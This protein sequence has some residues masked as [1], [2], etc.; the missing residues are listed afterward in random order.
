MDP[1]WKRAGDRRPGGWALRFAIVEGRRDE[2]SGFSRSQNIRKG[3]W[4]DALDTLDRLLP[5][6]GGL[7]QAELDRTLRGHAGALRARKTGTT[8]AGET[9]L[10][11]LQ[12][13]PA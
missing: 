11:M 1:C 6:Q 2:P 8:P 4:L 3:D 9:E 7:M 10:K 13:N 5:E 12:R